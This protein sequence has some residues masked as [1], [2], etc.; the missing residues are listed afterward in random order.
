[1]N[2]AEQGGHVR[3]NHSCGG[4]ITRDGE[5]MKRTKICEVEEKPNCQL[6][7]GYQPINAGWQLLGDLSLH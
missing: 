1:V 7:I 5:G 2:Q 3:V 4:A 6:S